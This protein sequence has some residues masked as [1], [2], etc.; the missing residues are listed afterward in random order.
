MKNYFKYNRNL[1]LKMIL[2][3]YDFK[4]CMGHR[5]NTALKKMSEVSMNFIQIHKI[6]KNIQN[7]FQ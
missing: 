6:E 5:F 2:S 7:Y 1:F 4:Y 3:V